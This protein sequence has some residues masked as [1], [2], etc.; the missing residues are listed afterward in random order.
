[1]IL[2]RAFGVSEDFAGRKRETA[3]KGTGVISL[4]GGKVGDHSVYLILRLNAALP[5]G[6]SRVDALSV[7]PGAVPRVT[8]QS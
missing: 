2:G 3:E 7:L 6:P 5:Q 1:M 8:R 4:A